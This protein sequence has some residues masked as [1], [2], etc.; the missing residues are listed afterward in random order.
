V[1]SPDGVWVYANNNAVRTSDDNAFLTGE[2][3]GER[4]IAISP[5]GRFL[6]STNEGSNVKVV[7]ISMVGGLPVTTFM[8]NIDDV[9][10]RQ[11]EAYGIDLTNTGDQGVVSFRGSDTVRIFDAMT[12]SFV[13]PPIPMEVTTC[14]G[15]TPSGDEPKQLVINH[16][17]NCLG[18]P[19][20]NQNGTRDFCDIAQ[21]P[22]D[23]PSC[24]DCNS[25]GRPDGCEI[26]SGDGR[27]WGCLPDCNEN[28]IPDECDID[29][30]TS[31]DANGNGIPDDCEC[32]CP[33]FE[34]ACEL[35][36][37]QTASGEGMSVHY[38]LPQVDS[39]CRFTCGDGTGVAGNQECIVSCIPEPGSWFPIGDTTVTCTSEPYTPPAGVTG[40]EC[41]FTVTVLPV[42]QVCNGEFFG[43][44]YFNGVDGVVEGVLQSD[45]SV[46][47]T[48]LSAFGEGVNIRAEGVVSAC[49]DVSA[50]NEEFQ[51][52]V[53]GN[54][55]ASE[56]CFGSG[57]FFGFKGIS[58]DWSITI[59]TE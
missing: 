54:I 3:S 6:Y 57:T 22:T 17:S 30:G 43:D 37:D 58:G 35:I 44:Y 15:A 33:D 41:S 23:D 9:D 20:C 1:V 53:W 4:G 18:A 48:F 7:E 32:A 31:Q 13:G 16:T 34:I 5:D 14:S 45:G 36:D 2:W 21:C 8:A 52:E 28:G 29:E 24:Q 10:N 51:I 26:C 40:D 19:D 46:V 42:P 12:L 39:E 25:N 59:G 55:Y 49:G 11:S 50:V 38:D 47:I 27:V 56:G